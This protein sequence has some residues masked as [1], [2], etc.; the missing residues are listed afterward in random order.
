MPCR[1]RVATVNVL[2]VTAA[3]IVRGVEAYDA[4]FG[5]QFVV[6]LRQRVYDWAYPRRVKVNGRLLALDLEGI[7]VGLYAEWLVFLGAGYRL[8]MKYGKDYTR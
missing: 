2:R 5:R 7:R 6:P 1:L 8:L 3:A 4:W